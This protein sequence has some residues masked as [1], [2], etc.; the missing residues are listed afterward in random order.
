VVQCASY[1]HIKLNGRALNKA[2]PVKHN[3]AEMV[4]IPLCMLKKPHEKWVP[5]TSVH[6]NPGTWGGGAG[7]EG[8]EGRE[9]S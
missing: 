5:S 8:R 2:H 1:G 4:L 6:N 3:R 9:Y 7:G